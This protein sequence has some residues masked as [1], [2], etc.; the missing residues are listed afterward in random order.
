MD[1]I[2][3]DIEDSERIVDELWL[4]LAREMAEMDPHNELAD[5][6]REPAVAYRREQL[7]SR[8]TTCRVLADGDSW[9]G[10][11]QATYRESPPVFA[12]GDAA[13]V[14][15][16]WVAPDYRG[17][18]HGERLVAAV[19][20][21]GCERNAERISLNVDERNDAARNLYASLGY[22]PRRLELDKH[23]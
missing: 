2:T 17:E 16:L 12:R 22:E 5:E 21:W 1:L 7:S 3:P 8:D 11:V 18:G 19:E 20:A 10:Y 15:E 23:L 6:V 9:A 13:H 4:P 14:Q